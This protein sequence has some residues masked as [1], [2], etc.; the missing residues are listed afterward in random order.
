MSYYLEHEGSEHLRVLRS[1]LFAWAKDDQDIYLVSQVG[2][3]KQTIMDTNKQ[4]N[5]PA[6]QKQQTITF[7]HMGKDR[8]RSYINR[9]Y[10]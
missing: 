2:A 4:K 5:T 9:A 7:T 8:L 10:K 6:Y 1:T 3:Q